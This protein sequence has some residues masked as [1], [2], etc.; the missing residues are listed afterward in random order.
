MSTRKKFPQMEHL[1]KFR[2]YF[3]TSHKC[4]S[5]PQTCGHDPYE[6][7]GE[8][9]SKSRTSVVHSCPAWTV[10]KVQ[11]FFFFSRGGSLE[12]T[13]GPITCSE[14]NTQ[15][16]MLAITV[17]CGDFLFIPQHYW[18]Y[19][20]NHPSLLVPV[21]FICEMLLCVQHTTNFNNHLMNLCS[22]TLV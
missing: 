12:C 18:K 6:P 9:L 17:N 5:N 7:T 8:V 11:E 22:Y 2:G 15:G 19:T 10:V 21:G 1:A 16:K 4:P 20:I 13:L 14:S 3:G